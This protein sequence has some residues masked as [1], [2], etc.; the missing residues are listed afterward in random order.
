MGI[1]GLS[2]LR[3]ALVPNNRIAA[4]NHTILQITDRTSFRVSWNQSTQQRRIVI[5][6]K[7]AIASAT[8]NPGLLDVVDAGFHRHDGKHPHVIRPSYFPGL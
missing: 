4:A 1:F 5:P 3:P 2:W 6:G 7:L 8:R